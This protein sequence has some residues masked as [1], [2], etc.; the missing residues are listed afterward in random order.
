M[1]QDTRQ[2][3]ERHGAFRLFALRSP[4]ETDPSGAVNPTRFLAE[5]PF[6][7]AAVASVNARIQAGGA[8]HAG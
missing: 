5:Q 4:K 3:A 2:N 6:V 1:P 7:Y 8:T